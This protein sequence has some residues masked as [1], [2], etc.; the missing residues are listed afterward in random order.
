MK[1]LAISIAAAL[2]LTGC[3]SR[4]QAIPNQWPNSPVA[5]ENVK[6][7]YERPKAHFIDLGS[8][9]AGTLSEC[10]RLAARLGADAI[11]VHQRP[12]SAG[13]AV[14]V[15]KLMPASIG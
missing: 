3:M 12:F 5:I 7:I 13:A 4:S 1:T 2:T 6:I 8:V 11:W 9:R 15:I 14:T 10:R